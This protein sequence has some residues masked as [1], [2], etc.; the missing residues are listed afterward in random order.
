MHLRTLEATLLVCC[1]MALAGT[2]LFMP[3][4]PY[5]PALPGVDMDLDLMES[6]DLGDPVEKSPFPPIYLAWQRVVRAP[7][8]AILRGWW[9]DFTSLG[10]LSSPVLTLGVLL[11]LFL[12]ISAEAKL[13]LFYW[14]KWYDGDARS[15][16]PNDSS[17]GLR[18]TTTASYRIRQ[19]FSRLLSAQSLP[20]PSVLL[21][22]LAPIFVSVA[23]VLLMP[24]PLSVATKAPTH[25][26]DA[27]IET[28][29][30]R[31]N[32]T[33]HVI[34][35]GLGTNGTRISDGVTSTDLPPHLNSVGSAVLPLS[36]IAS[37]FELAPDWPLLL[38]VR[39]FAF[40]AITLSAAAAAQLYY[41]DI[42]AA[43]HSRRF[44][45]HGAVNSEST[46]ASELTVPEVN[47]LADYQEGNE[48]RSRRRRNLL[49]EDCG[50]HKP[51]QKSRSASRGRKG[52]VHVI[53]S[54]VESS[55][56]SD[57]LDAQP[58][59][60]HDQDFV[61]EDAQRQEF[62]DT[63]SCVPV[64]GLCEVDEELSRIQ[65]GAIHVSTTAP[66]PQAQSLHD[67]QQLESKLRRLPGEL[68]TRISHPL[69]IE[70]TPEGYTYCGLVILGVICPF[71]VKIHAEPSK[72]AGVRPHLRAHFPSIRT[73]AALITAAIPI[74]FPCQLPNHVTFFPFPVPLAA[75]SRFALA[76]AAILALNVFARLLPL[77]FSLLHGTFPPSEGLT[78]T[79]LLTL[80]LTLFFQHAIRRMA[81]PVVR[82]IA[83]MIPRGP[84]L[85][86]LL[87]SIADHFESLETFVFGRQWVAEHFRRI[88]AQAYGRTGSPSQLIFLPPALVRPGRHMGSLLGVLAPFAPLRDPVT[89]ASL[90]IPCATALLV[91]IASAV[92]K[93]WYYT[94]SSKAEEPLSKGK[95]A[96]TRQLKAA[97]GRPKINSSIPLLLVI[98]LGIALLLW[99][100]AWLL[101]G[102]EPFGWL[103]KFLLS[104]SDVSPLASVAGLALAHAPPPLAG[105]RAR[106][107]IISLVLGSPRLLVRML[108]QWIASMNLTQASLTLIEGL[109]QPYWEKTRL[110]QHGIANPA[111]LP[112]SSFFYLFLLGAPPRVLLFIYCALV[113]FF[114]ILFIIP[115][116]Q[117]SNARFKWIPSLPLI[118]VRKYYHFLASAL[119]L[120]PLLLDLSFLS[121][122]LA[123][124][125]SF[126][127]LFEFIR[128]FRLPPIG[129]SLHR[130]M[131][132]FVDARDSGP[133][134]VT[135]IYLLIGCAIPVW[136]MLTLTPAL[137]SFTSEAT[138]PLAKFASAVTDVARQYFASI[139]STSLQEG[140]AAMSAVSTN[141]SD[142]TVVADL[143]TSV[144]PLLLSATLA[145]V[146]H[147]DV[148]F[149]GLLPALTGLL[150]LG[151]GDSAASLAGTWLKHVH[152][153]SSEPSSNAS[154]SKGKIA[155]I[156][157]LARTFAQKITSF[158]R[159]PGSPKTLGGTF[160]AFLA[161]MLSAWCIYEFCRVFAYVPS[162]SLSTL[163]QVLTGAAGLDDRG[164]ELGTW[165]LIMVG[166]GVASIAVVLLEAWTEHID[167]LFLPMVYFALV[168]LLIPAVPI[169]GLV[170]VESMFY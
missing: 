62:C 102:Q 114:G 10:P 79:S 123:G 113:L 69:T 19:T 59:R 115:F 32:L 86:A 99:P 17:S 67:R 137:S 45:N 148:F 98:A 141:T 142:P 158:K 132:G 124:A 61:P 15:Q 85:E 134:F 106:D 74:I 164:I 1:A 36:T 11:T 66:S 127:V 81:I 120:P 140:A 139:S 129:T 110:F 27:S 21:G 22:L 83:R 89:S 43:F 92:L 144:D 58:G 54:E 63:S 96:S 72:R 30:V 46:Q 135:H 16:S 64:P 40:L 101:I 80:A 28:A 94:P 56:S 35:L 112:D 116:S 26:P 125:L 12:A 159:W 122:A 130:F 109:V 103:L 37:V 47:S 57:E 75:P 60:E 20:F 91:Y 160:S 162:E 49:K 82:T 163:K 97:D 154:A 108:P 73:L 70:I 147:A 145:L 100:A 155:S 65:P 51:A 50:A 93:A 76:V 9:L 77:A 138:L 111:A 84:A 13:R 165:S 121:I 34:E 119:L 95:N 8:E 146:A 39:A 42:E 149:T 105:L 151:V 41:G 126:L 88:V 161:M 3:Y 4:R 29:T 118:I 48:F 150:V 131:R 68:L 55:A 23:A 167:N 136:M 87:L 128:V 24:H 166:L 90:A 7:M 117:S 5:K 104:R 18:E 71:F 44:T 168:A 169:L 157:S 78:T 2:M 31:A 14:M 152:L 170:P 33:R 153:T 107:A 25:R 133:L 38:G 53:D 6:G 143:A 156:S 52:P